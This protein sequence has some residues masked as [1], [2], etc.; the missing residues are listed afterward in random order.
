MKARVNSPTL[1]TVVGPKPGDLS[2]SRVNPA[3]MPRGGP[4]P[5]LLQ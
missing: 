5:L 1:Y 4:H 3:E 2:M